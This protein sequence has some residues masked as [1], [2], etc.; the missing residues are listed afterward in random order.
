ML[1]ALAPVL[2]SCLLVLTTPQ[3]LGAQDVCAICGKSA[4]VV[5]FD[6]DK[7]TG[8]KV[9][10]CEP[11]EKSFANCFVCGL[12][13]NPDT[14]GY[15]RLA[16]ARALCGRDAKTAVL[17]E[18]EGVRVFREI[19]DSL[20]R[21]FSRFTGFPDTNIDLAMVDRV[22][23][24]ELFAL[25]GNDYHCPNVFGYTHS[26]TNGG[27]FKHEISLMTGLPLSWL[28]ATCAHELTHAWVAENLSTGR[29]ATLSR[30]AEEGFC[31]LIAFLSCAARNNEEQKAMIL[32]NAYTRGQIDLFVTAEASYGLNDVLD[33]VRFGTDAKLSA[34]DPARVHQVKLPQTKPA[35]PAHL[36]LLPVQT[37]PLPT[38][39]QL[40]AILWDPKRPLALINS[41][42]LGVGE[43]GKVRLADSTVAVRCLGIT[44]TSVRIQTAG[45]EQEQ[46]LRLPNK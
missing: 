39:L 6:E 22:H 7:V 13:A 32:R 23:L 42:T 20:D 35:P 3:H 45:S 5:Y 41:L 4:L 8:K 10:V 27:T 31:E 30:D 34:S 38:T 15:V 40:K 24:Q 29:K 33:W 16:D 11:C 28:Q 2:W 37:P 9:L 17:T 12:P 44:P 46:E 18:R 21:L 1:G 36:A 43:E 26:E 25:A 14:A 19:R